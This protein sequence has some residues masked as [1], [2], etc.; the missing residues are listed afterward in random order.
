MKNQI[1]NRCFFLIGAQELGQGVRSFKKDE[2]LNVMHIAV[3]TVLEP[4]GYYAFDGDDEQGWPHFRLLKKLPPL[5]QKE[6]E[7][8]M[9]K[10][11]IEYFE[12]LQLKKPE[13]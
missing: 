12:S 6:Q 5:N 1:Y 11:V 9:K 10:A 7:T 8:F 4:Y 2:K 13:A 3:C